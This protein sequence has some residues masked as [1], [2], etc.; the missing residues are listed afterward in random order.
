MHNSSESYLR[1]NIHEQQTNYVQPDTEA[2]AA[3]AHLESMSTRQ[4]KTRSEKQTT[5]SGAAKTE[6]LSQI[7]KKP[8]PKSEADIS[9]SFLLLLMQLRSQEPPAHL[10][11][12]MC[13][14]R[15][16]ADLQKL[17]V[18]ARPFLNNL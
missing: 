2:L 12:E 9:P 16:A 10:T 4:L 1:L 15:A 6:V 13:I 17:S 8:K 5:D 11:V 3:F 7:A 14:H 18:L